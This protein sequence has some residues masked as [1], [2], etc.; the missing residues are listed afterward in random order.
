MRKLIALV[1]TTAA[2]LFAGS[3]KAAQVDLFLTQTGPAA[4]TW[5][6]T[7]NTDASFAQL[8]SVAVQIFSA[9]AGAF[10]VG[11]TNVV[12]DPLLPTGFSNYVV[13]PPMRLG[14]GPGTQGYMVAGATTGFLLGTWTGTSAPTLGPADPGDGDTATDADFTPLD[15]SITT[16]PF[17]VVPEPSA[18]ILLG[19]GLAGLSMARRKA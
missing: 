14:L 16:V 1:A 10:V 6:L 12:I 8:G 5:N 4:T 13:G 18:M 3:A 11:Q 17:S 2:L 19:L 15:F 7:A 9:T